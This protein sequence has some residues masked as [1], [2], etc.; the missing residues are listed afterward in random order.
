MNNLNKN[1]AS[2]SSND[3]SQNIHDLIAGIAK[4]SRLRRAERAEIARELTSHFQEALAA[5]QTAEDAVRTYGDARASSQT[6]RAA[7][8]AKRSPLDRALGLTFKWTAPVFGLF[9]V[10]Y[11]CTAVYMSMDGP[12]VS[13][14][15][16]K[17]IRD[18]FP[19]ANS[20]DQLA[21]P[22]YRDALVQM[23]LGM[24]DPRRMSHG[25]VAACDS[26]RPT[27]PNWPAA[28]DWTSDNQLHIAALCVASKRPILG[29]PVAVA[30]SDADAALLGKEFQE[31]TKLS[32]AKDHTALT[33]F[34]AFE[35]LLPPLA[36]FRK[37]T[38]IL[39]TD[40]LQALEQEDGERATRDAEAMIAISIHV[41]EGRILIGDLVGMAIRSK[42]V[43]NIIMALEWKPSAWSDAQLARLQT[44][45]RSVPPKLEHVDFTSEQLMFEDVVQR[46]YTDD[47]NGDGR[48]A[49][50]W[51][52]LQ[53]LQFVESVSSG[54]NIRNRVNDRLTLAAT[55]LSNP[56][57]AFAVA[58][59][60]DAINHYMASM[61]RLE[62]GLDGSLS[63]ANT[64][65][66]KVDQDFQDNMHEQGT[67]YFL[68]NLLMPAMAKA[69][70]QFR[71]D[72]AIRDACVVSI[73]AELFHRAHG[74]WPVNAADLAPLCGGASPKDPWSGNPIAM[75]TDANGFR[76]WSVGRN[77]VNELGGL[78]QST[79]AS[80]SLDWVWLAPRGNLDRWMAKPSITRNA[81]TQSPQ[82]ANH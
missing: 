2:G 6:L 26:P 37:A 30:A 4:N 15:A 39:A 25:V 79:E 63:D 58:T 14:D 27:D 71:L 23:G 33:E 62:I 38:N 31:S 17:R 76:M 41:Q 5:G 80:T 49:P 73:A 10:L 1:A 40:M 9:L 44:A 35:L 11:L 82:E 55:F 7:A 50:Q 53:F 68:E 81:S 70:F 20:P 56:L 24:D 42:A 65:M 46:L 75:E 12:K 22:A 29:F 72:K 32:A 8:I 13:F 47:G 28:R 77:G 21:W 52:Q 60:K 59:R 64:A 66:A 54:D 67:R 45:L 36:V 43:N 78:E 19:V 16:I 51:K 61:M 69:S 74:T 48:F 18:S 34:P 3:L 57:A